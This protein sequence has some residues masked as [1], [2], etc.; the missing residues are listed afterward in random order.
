MGDEN[1]V[2]SGH[3]AAM[4]GALNNFIEIFSANKEETFEATM[5]AGVK[6][7]ADAFKLDRFSIWR[8]TSKP[9]GLHGGEIFRWDRESGGT[10][11]PRKGLD[12]MKYSEFAPRWEKVLAADEVINSP[13]KLMP[14]ALLL[15][16]YG[17]VSVL[18]TPLFINNNFW[19]FAL[20][21]DLNNERYFR[22]ED[23]DMLRSAA[24][25]CANTVLR[26]DME[27]EIAY[28]KEF[29][30]AILD[31]SPLGFTIFDENA[32][33]IDCN[34]TLAKLLNTT[35]KFYIEHFNRF[36]PE[37]QSDGS[38]SA[39]KTV[40]LIKRALNGEKLLL[41]WTLCTSTGEPIHYEITMVRAMYKGK[42]VVLVYQYNLHVRKTREMELARAKE[43]NELQLAKLNLVVK[44]TKIALWDME[45]IQDDPVNPYNVFTWSVEFRRMLGYS[46][47]YDFPNVLGSWSSLLHPQDK[48][49]TLEL[50]AKHMLDK[51]GNTPYD[52]EYRLLKKNGEYAYFRATGEC[53]RD[54]D[55]NAI[56]VAGALMDIT[57]SKNILLDKDLEKEAAEAAN[58]EKSNFLANMSHELRTPLNVVI[59][60]TN[61]ILEDESL[62]EHV[63][64]NLV[65]INNAGTSLLKIVNDVLDLSKIESGKITL[66]SEEYHMS[67]LLN[68]IIT[69]T[70]TRLGE[71]PV[72]FIL[73]IPD[74]L[75]N[76][77]YGDDLRLKQV[78]TNLLSNAVKYTREGSITLKVN[79]D[80]EG[81]IMLMEYAV[82]DTGMGIPKDNLKN[83]FQEYTQVD[84]KANRR[85]D[86]AGLGLPITKRLVDMMDG[87]IDVESEEG[88]GST[89]SFRIMQGF[90]DDTVLGNE[91][92]EK[93]RN[94]R[95]INDKRADSQK[96]VRINLNYA[97]VLVVD[98]MQT[99]LDVASGLLR[100]YQ[101]HVD[102]LNNGQAAIDRIQKGEPVY[103]AIFMDHMMPEMDGIETADRIRALG[104]DYAKKIPIIAL[105][106]NAIQGTEKMFYAH[107][108]QDFVTKPIDIMELDAALRKWVRDEKYDEVALESEPSEDKEMEIKIPGVDTRKGLALYAGDTG[109]YLPL[110]RSY[111]TNT[112]ATLEKL[113]N[114]SAKNL[115]SYVI[116]VHGLKGTSAGIGAEEVRAQALE[117]ENLSRAGDL[118]GVLARNDKLIADAELIVASVKEWLDKNDVQ[119]EKPRKKAPDRELLAKLRESCESYDMDGIDEA[120]KELESFDYEEEGEL[121][122]WVRKKIDMSKMGDVSSRLNGI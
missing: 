41:E 87:R 111:I 72:K 83:I 103:S 42:Y 74:D 76:K 64:E 58:R 70:L 40:E 75:P 53:I 71:K 4:S 107:D 14:E 34:D 50:F 94:F 97:R 27:R 18:V 30:S 38:K 60:L 35:K 101:L 116:S 15:K 54:K 122:T 24:F 109:I 28:A 63:T 6:E 80:R 119:E 79:C 112:P 55:G 88:K 59:G 39:D 47:E 82:I 5:T 31:A 115:Q 113:K 99:N 46:D 44:A 67:S 2:L 118:Q 45:V 106:A 1:T 91:V 90:V 13:V 93:L 7:M 77:L 117:L 95:Y 85:V 92:A 86:G 78:L 37:F 57:E 9:D 21:E 104:T 8:N 10:T 98:D 89:F 108:F 69:L 121:V 96:L 52:V 49:R 3:Y 56:R 11:V 36:M 66:S 73:D 19:G 16:S 100:K 43:L 110:L 81:S 12:D 51:T 26:A 23:I 105:T 48:E 102:C 65:K 62:S 33:V 17:C 22:E 120:M 68:D 114:V 20:L 32:R 25:M 61:L 84:D 29:N